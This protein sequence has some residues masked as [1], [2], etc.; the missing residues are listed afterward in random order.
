MHIDGPIPLFVYGTLRNGERFA[1]YLEEFARKP[2][3]VVDYCLKENPAGDVYITRVDVGDACSKVHG[4]IYKVSLACLRRINHLENASGSF[5]KGYE[6]AVLD[7][8]DEKGVAVHA[9]YFRLKQESKIVRSGDY[10]RL[11]LLDFIEKYLATNT[12]Q[13]TDEN[14]IVAIQQHING[15]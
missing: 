6:L 14:L 1:F 3:T 13:L 4:E 11:D 12:A 10:K 9:L 15:E 2:C 8:R 7:G 5:P